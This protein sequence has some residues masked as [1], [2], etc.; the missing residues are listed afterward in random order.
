MIRGTT[1]TFTL[2]IDDENLDLSQAENVYVTIKQANTTITKT[3][4]YLNIDENVV[5]CWLTES[6][7]FR[8]KENIEASIQINWTYV[9]LNGGKKRAATQAHKIMIDRQLLNSEIT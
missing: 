4:E 9:E 2:T 5:E 3:G 8:L 7:S 6:E 1:P